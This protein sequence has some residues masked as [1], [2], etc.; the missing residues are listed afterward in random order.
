MGYG[1]HD[2]QGAVLPDALTA[3]SLA[4]VADNL[5]LFKVCQPITVY[6]IGVFI[7]T[8]C[9]VTSPVVDFDKRIT[10]G[11]DTGRV[12]KGVGTMTF[13]AVASCAIS[14]VARKVL[15]TPVDLNPGDE[16][17]VQVTTAATAGAGIPYLLFRPRDEVAANLANYITAT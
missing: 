12:D 9:T 6:E 10:A 16:V 3:V 13:P 4:G 15:T 7:T 14:K 17:S 1:N 8:A 2:P 5:R 11:S